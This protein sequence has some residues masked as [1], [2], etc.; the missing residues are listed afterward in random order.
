M[1]TTPEVTG[2]ARRAVRYARFTIGYNVFEGI[3]AIAA[4]TVAGAVSLVGFGV[5][6]GI[7]V[8]SAAVVLT[9]LLADIR[10]GEP[11]EARERRALKFIAVTF[12]ALAAYVIIEGVRDLVTGETPDTSIVGIAL[13]GL[14]LVLMP[15]LARAKRQAGRQMN[16]RLV[17][18]DASETTLCA[19]LSLSTF[20]G[21][22]SYAVFNFT[23]V[24][25]VAGFV[26]AAFAV[27]EG[28]EAWEG[29]LVLQSDANDETGA[30]M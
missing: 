5:D 15:W 6:S 3:V 28:K 20:A 21:L 30:G 4:G 7:E 13:T 14:S 2:P 23:W 17:V 19:W 1:S 24:D 27:G 29:E 10:G 22:L 16:S 12:F 11:D 9:R 18:A 25:P 26:I 8:A